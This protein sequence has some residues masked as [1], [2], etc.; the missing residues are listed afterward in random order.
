MDK[1]K[2]LLLGFGTTPIALFVI[3]QL[4]PVWL[5][6][7]NPAVVAEPAWDSPET[8]AL[9]KRACF[10]CHSNETVWPWY[11]RVAPVSWLVTFDVV[12]ARRELNF[13]TW[14]ANGQRSGRKDK[15]EEAA[16]K[17]EEGEMPLEIYVVQHPEAKLT[18]QE[19]EQLIQGFLTMSKP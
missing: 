5:L 6:Q 10:D 7:T 15:L 1:K 2:L 9:A 13:S 17:I 4:I 14:N 3:M 12:R 19:K 8:R 11:S 18:A 16:E